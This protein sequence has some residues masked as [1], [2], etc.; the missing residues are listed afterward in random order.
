MVQSLDSAQRGTPRDG[1]AMIH[2]HGDSSNNL[3]SAATSSPENEIELDEMPYSKGM[4]E[5]EPL[6]ERHGSVDAP[7]PALPEG[8][9]DPVYEAKATVLNTALQEI[10][11]GRYQWQL[12]VVI[13][14]VDP[15]SVQAID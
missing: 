10:G 2:N 3:A 7:A 15:L 5:S 6:V 8:S 13:G 4:E 9:L 12:F 1:C 11:M 14:C